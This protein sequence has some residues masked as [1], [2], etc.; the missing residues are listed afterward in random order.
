MLEEILKSIK[1]Y[2]RG[3]RG[4]KKDCSY[5]LSYTFFPDRIGSLPNSKC[6]V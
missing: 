3:K 1:S 2:R 5:E 6:K 4:N